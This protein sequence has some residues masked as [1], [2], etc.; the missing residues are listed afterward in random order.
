MNATFPRYWLSAFL[1][2]LGD[3]VRL[4]AFPLLALQ[5]TSSPAAVA[6]V[7]AVQ[8]LPWIVLG[9][10]V[11]TLVDRRDLR[12]TM[13]AVDLVRA[14]VI[15]ALAITV[16]LGAV[17]LAL[18]YL[19][20]FVT[21]LGG[22][23]RDTATATAVPR[24]VG[25]SGLETAN[26]RLVAGTLIGNELAGPALGGWLFG[27]AAVL[28]FAFNAG[29][30]GIS[31]LLL[32]TLPSVFAPHKRSL[33]SGAL[34]SAARDLWEGLNW[35]RRDRPIRNLVLAVALV[36]LA[37]GAYLAIL[38]LYVTRVLNLDAGA[39]GLLLGVGAIGGI[40]AGACCARVTSRIGARGVLFVSVLTMA[41]AQ[42]ML[43]LTSNLACTMVALVFSSGAFAALNVTS[44]T[45]R[46]RRSPEHLLG[47]INSAYLTVGRGAEATGALAGGG[48]ATAAGVQAPIL[49][50]VLP[51]I[52]AAMLVARPQQAGHATE[53]G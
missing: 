30:L 13:V 50:G 9:L 6:A 35:L 52:G 48:L 4:A 28:P 31:I 5:V 16:I 15:A 38:A 36:A 18:I 25:T 26:G 21:G 19:T 47:R 29:G 40:I 44:M 2:D 14:V 1:A 33:D 23:V 8:G 43:G 46:Q 53:D 45:L 51:L 32:L 20:A 11:G 10:G 3:G 41:A 12:V 27:I 17:N 49:A 22:M 34:R 37:D 39:Y 7:S 24:L 42:L